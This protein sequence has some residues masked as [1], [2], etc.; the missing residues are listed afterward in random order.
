MSP[1][2]AR[3][4]A[5]QEVE[6]RRHIV[7]RFDHPVEGPLE[8]ECHVLHVPDSDQRLVVYCA[9][10]GSPTHAAFRRLAAR[11]PLPLTRST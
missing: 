6:E 10:P 4:W 1:R 9:E 2:F 7:K 8:F 3:M 5:E 11:E